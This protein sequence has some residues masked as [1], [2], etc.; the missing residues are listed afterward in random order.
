VP[1]L[2]PHGACERF[3]PTGI[4]QRTIGDHHA[5][6]IVLLLRATEI[7]NPSQFISSEDTEI[8]IAG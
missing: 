7:R 3:W 4:H 5:L 1:W 8:F 6:K 2:A